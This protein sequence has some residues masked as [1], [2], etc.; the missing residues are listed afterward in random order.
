M[1][2]IV[3]AK[4]LIY[5]DSK[6]VKVFYFVS[7]KRHAQIK[8]FENA[9]NDTHDGIGH[10]SHRRHRQMVKGSKTTGIHQK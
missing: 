7:A 5:L 3:K 4:K 1:Y 6:S 2:V 10:C 8:R 9:Q